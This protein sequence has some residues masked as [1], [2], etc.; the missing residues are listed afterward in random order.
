VVLLEV[1]FEMCTVGY[2]ADY[3]DIGFVSCCMCC[4][5]TCCCILLLQE[6][7]DA[8]RFCKFHTGIAKGNTSDNTERQTLR[9]NIRGTPTLYD[10]VVSATLFINWAILLSL[11]TDLEI[12]C[13]SSFILMSYLE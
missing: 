2:V 6:W 4:I 5:C 10:N 7:Q 8:R 1:N 13:H 3:S 12:Q 11:L 9:K